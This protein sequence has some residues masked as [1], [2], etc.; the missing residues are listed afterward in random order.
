MCLC[1][2]VVRAT[3]RI[4]AAPS[5]A[6]DAAAAAAAASCTVDLLTDVIATDLIRGGTAAV[7]QLNSL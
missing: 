2:L 6:A 5:A 4:L 3:R 7:R 1:V